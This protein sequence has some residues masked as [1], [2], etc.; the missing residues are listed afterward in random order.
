MRM[1]P[2]KQ[3]VL[4]LCQQA[5]NEEDANELLRIFLALDQ[6]VRGETAGETI[7][8]EEAIMQADRIMQSKR[9]QNVVF[10]A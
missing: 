2:Q 5:M 6:A 4:D 1:L 10:E 9:E 3:T 8:R 7:L